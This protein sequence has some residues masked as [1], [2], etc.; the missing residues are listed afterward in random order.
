MDF[1]HSKKSIITHSGQ[2]HADDV[3]AVA[4]LQILFGENNVEITRTRDEAI[5][6]KGNIVIDVGGIYDESKDRFDHHQTE[7]AGKRENGIPYSSLG[8]VWKKYGKNICGSEKV[9][10]HLD[11]QLVQPIDAG[12]NGVEISKPLKLFF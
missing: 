6:A 8:L 3:F 11:A 2:F 4:A 12:D 5:I 1:R 10:N 7:G 9:A